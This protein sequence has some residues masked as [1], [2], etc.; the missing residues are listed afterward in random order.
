V[1][2]KPTNDTLNLFS[3][4]KLEQPNQSTVQSNISDS[5][6]DRTHTHLFHNKYALK[7]LGELGEILF[8]Q[9]EITASLIVVSQ[10]TKPPENTH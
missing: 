5:V 7:A 6:S 9:D 1:N 2:S 3:I 4:T 8:T 10:Q